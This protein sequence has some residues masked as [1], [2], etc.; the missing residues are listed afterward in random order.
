MNGSENGYGGI[1]YYD[2]A[3]VLWVGKL[4]Q[5]NGPGEVFIIPDISGNKNQTACKCHDE[6]SLC[7]SQDEVVSDVL[8]YCANGNVVEV[9]VPCTKGNLPQARAF[10]S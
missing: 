10:L 2:P 6:D 3:L 9:N 5:H 8:C 1:S 4:G 7:M